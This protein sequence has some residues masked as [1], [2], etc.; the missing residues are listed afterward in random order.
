MVG[1]VG[2]GWRCYFV[3]PH[4]KMAARSQIGTPNLQAKQKHQSTSYSEGK[5]RAYRAASLKVPDTKAHTRQYGVTY[6]R[7]ISMARKRW[8]TAYMVYIGT[9]ERHVQTMIEGL[10][11]R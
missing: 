10:R 9:D 7:R 5:H 11:S 3:N 4:E 8:N 2:I 1:E 6:P